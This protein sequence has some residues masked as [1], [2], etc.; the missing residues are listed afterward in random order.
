MGRW[1]EI[2]LTLFLRT[3]FGNHTY[4]VLLVRT[5]VGLVAATS[6]VNHFSHLIDQSFLPPLDLVPC[7][8][9]DATY[10]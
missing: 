4:I 1:P 5:T 9:Q 3:I 10:G 7:F 6:A 2:T 8:L